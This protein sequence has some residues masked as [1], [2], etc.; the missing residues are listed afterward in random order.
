MS[1]RRN[2]KQKN[3]KQKRNSNTGM[4]PSRLSLKTWYCGA[5]VEPVIVYL[6]LNKKQK[7]KKQKIV[8]TTL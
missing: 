8:N 6:G 7:K 5:T 1:C 2:N 4:M 3:K